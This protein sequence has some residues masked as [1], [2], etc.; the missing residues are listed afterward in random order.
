MRIKEKVRLK[1]LD[2]IRTFA[3]LLIILVHF[4]NSL[5]DF[6]ITIANNNYLIKDSFAGWSLG[7]VG[8]SL[9]F[10]ISG[11]ALMVGYS[12][13]FNI[14]MYLKK[15]LKSIY[16]LSYINVCDVSCTSFFL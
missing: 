12:D 6:G 14:V 5:V 8:V 3:V 4:N 2:A 10:V 13:E 16:P 7:T 11:A 15:R 1:Y 9:F